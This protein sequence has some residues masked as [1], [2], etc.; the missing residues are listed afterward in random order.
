MTEKKECNNDCP[1]HMI[2]ERMERLEKVV[3]GDSQEGI[4][5]RLARIEE[6]VKSLS[7]WT[8]MAVALVSGTFLS[9]LV[10]L[11]K[12]LVL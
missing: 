9:V 5:S 6:K 3:Y 11:V 7:F 4:V 8:K 2:I 12:V 10:M 1:M